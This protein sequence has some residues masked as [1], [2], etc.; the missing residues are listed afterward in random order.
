MPG[1]LIQR[2]DISTGAVSFQ[3][4]R[5]G[6]PLGKA[7][8]ARVHFAFTGANTAVSMPHGL[9]KRPSTYTV[10]ASGIASGSGAPVIYTAD[11]VFWSTSTIIQ[12]KSNTATS[13]CE[14]IIRE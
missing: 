6:R 5:F 12:L 7:R 9:G 8:E 3:K 1:P 4:R 13:W 10:V 11:P 14:V 2:K